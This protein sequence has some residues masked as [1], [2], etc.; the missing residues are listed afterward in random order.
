MR[1]LLLVE[2]TGAQL[3]CQ[4]TATP[5][6][7]ALGLVVGNPK[8]NLNSSILLCNGLLSSLLDEPTWSCVCIPFDAVSAMET[9]D[10]TFKSAWIYQPPIFTFALEWTT[11]KEYM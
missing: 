2:K 10:N 7:G 4:R 3:Q 8:W 9:D 6:G 5:C 11:Y 1:S